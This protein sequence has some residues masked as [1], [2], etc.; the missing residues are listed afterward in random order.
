M[1]NFRIFFESLPWTSLIPHNEIAVSPSDAFLPCVAFLGDSSKIIV[2]IGDNVPP[3]IVFS[4]TGLTSN[5]VYAAKKYDII[6]D[7][8]T[9]LDSMT[10]AADGIARIP[11]VVDP[12]NSKGWL[13]ILEKQS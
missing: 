11:Q 5:D 7:A 2:Y 4:L 1:T 10:V 6:L 8:Y 13:I 9:S 3:W 12:A